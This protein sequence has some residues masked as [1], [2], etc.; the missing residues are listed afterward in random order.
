M[1][2]ARVACVLDNVSFGSSDNGVLA[3]TFNMKGVYLIT[4]E[5]LLGSMP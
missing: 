1:D 4:Y 2:G 5:L 3:H